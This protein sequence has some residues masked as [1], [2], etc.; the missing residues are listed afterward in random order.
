MIRPLLLRSLV[1]L[2]AALPAA[3]ETLYLVNP[4][5]NGKGGPVTRLLVQNRDNVSRP[6]KVKFIPTGV[7]GTSTLSTKRYTIPARATLSLSITDALRG[8]GM[9]EIS[10]NDIL[11][12]T[13]ASWDLKVGSQNLTWSLPLLSAQNRFEKTETAYLRELAA[14]EAGMFKPNIELVNLSSAAAVCTIARFDALGVSILPNLVVNLPALSHK[15]SKNVVAGLGLA[16]GVAISAQVTCTQPFWALGTLVGTDPLKTRVL[17]PLDQSS[18][19]VVETVTLDQPGAFF[20]P[21]AGAS[22]LEIALPLVPTVAYR[23]AII[24][25]DMFVGDFSPIFTGLLGMFHVGGPRFNKT[26]YFGTF[27]RGIRD[28]SIFDLGVPVIEAA[29]QRNSDWTPQSNYHVRIVYD[30]EGGRMR[31]IVTE[32]EGLQRTI[33]GLECGIFNFDLADRDAPVFLA[34]G[35][36]GIADGAYYPPIGWKFTNLAVRVER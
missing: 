9:E 14:T 31:W 33:L 15:V 4:D 19:P 35:L 12:V 21:V 7:A 13:V 26:L 36:P 24:D 5:T 10:G 28:R 27:S 25:Y 22:Y 6:L 32:K 8:V 18:P 16:D 23:R 1:L 3:A 34:F 30:T 11:D 29:I 2:G 20:T 17:F